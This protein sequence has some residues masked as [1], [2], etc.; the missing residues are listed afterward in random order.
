MCNGFQDLPACQPATS[1]RV[2]PAVCLGS[3]FLYVGSMLSRATGEGTDDRKEV[4]THAL[5][6]EQV[7]SDKICF[8][9]ICPAGADALWCDQSLSPELNAIWEGAGP[10]Y[11]IP[12]SLSETY[13]YI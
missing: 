4:S 2:H 9:F 3:W 1:P 10:S 5:P 8:P 6:R 13:A 7:E 11:V 12:F